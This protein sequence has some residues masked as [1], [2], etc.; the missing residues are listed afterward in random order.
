MGNVQFKDGSVLFSDDSKVAMDAD[1]CCDG[2]PC[3]DCASHT[4]NATVTTTAAGGSGCDVDATYTFNSFTA[5]ATCEWLFDVAPGYELYVFYTTASG[6]WA[7]RIDSTGTTVYGD[8][9]TPCQ[10][11]TITGSISC[12]GGNLSGN[13]TLDGCPTPGCNGETATVVI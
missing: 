3:T 4:G 11:K 1:C 10:R 8:G 6:I 9:A 12:T 7:A 13:F 5:G 2:A